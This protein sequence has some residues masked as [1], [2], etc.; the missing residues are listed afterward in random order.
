TCDTPDGRGR[1]K[2]EAAARLARMV[3]ADLDMLGEQDIDA[4]A[5]AAARAQVR[6]IASGIR[7]VFARLGPG[8]RRLA[9]AAGHG[10]FLARMAAEAVGL[11]T[12]D[13]AEQLGPAA[14]AAAPAAAVAYLL[15]EV[16][17]T[18]L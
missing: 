2:T 17:A 8:S 6:Q 10:H 7:Q 18:G 14:A 12:R 15:A 5:N 16:H 1:T 3:C 9:V 11:E 4:I 13:L